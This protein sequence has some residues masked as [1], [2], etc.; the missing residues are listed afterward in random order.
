MKI[1][2]ISGADSGFS[3]RGSDKRPRIPY[4]IVID[5]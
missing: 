2:Y 5:I 4:L 1:S 3:D